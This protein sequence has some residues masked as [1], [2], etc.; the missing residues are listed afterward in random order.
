MRI[1]ITGSTD[2]IGEATA[3]HLVSLGHEVIVH[4]RNEEK[5]QNAL[6]QT[7]AS[8]GFVADLSNLKQV[9]E[10]AKKIKEKYSHLDVLINNAGVS[11]VQNP[12]GDDGL[13]VRFKVNVIAPYLLTKEL[14]GILDENSRVVNLSSAAQATVNLDALKG[15]ARLSD[16]NMVYAQ[17]KLALTEWTYYFARTQKPIFIA[18]NP[19]SFIGTKMVKET[20]GMAGV[21]LSFGV[22]A[23]TKAAVSEEFANANGK[24]FDN[25]IERF[26]NPHPDA[27]D[28]NVCDETVKTIEE[29][30]K[31][32]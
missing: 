22:N 3:K 13:D 18:V 12:F 16:S 25:D 28:E 23:L 10:L 26:S 27:L 6:K 7:G 11:I 32:I 2:G 31:K 17:G 29:I 30:L 19:K 24:Y 1:F 9:Y 15:D 8:D 20:Y 4:G 21:D 5:V 14:M